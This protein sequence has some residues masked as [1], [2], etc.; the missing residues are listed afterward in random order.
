M[1]IQIQSFLLFSPSR[2]T[3]SFLS[4]PVETAFDNEGIWIIR[5]MNIVSSQIFQLLICFCVIRL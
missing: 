2:L 1:Q 5:E 4:V 3:K